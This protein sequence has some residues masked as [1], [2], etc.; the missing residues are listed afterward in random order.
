M[1]R[2]IKQVLIILCFLTFGPS[3]GCGSS[4]LWHSGANTFWRPIDYFPYPVKNLIATRLHGK[5]IWV[6]TT[7]NEIYEIKYPCLENQI[8]WIKRNNIPPDLSEEPYIIYK[9]SNN[10]CENDNFLYPL[11]HKIRTCITSIDH[12]PDATWTVSLALTT[13]NKLWI[14]D[15]PWEAP[16]TEMLNMAISTFVGTAIGFS[17]GFFLFLTY[18]SKKD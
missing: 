4:I 14:W 1:R 18:I 5:E 3:L 15:S 8:C 17:I 10:K 9:V 16:D 11:F 6:K 13:I 12:A 2:T 7:E